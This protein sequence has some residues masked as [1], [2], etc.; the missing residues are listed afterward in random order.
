MIFRASKSSDG[1][2]PDK[3]MTATKP[4]NKVKDS[5]R[6]MEETFQPL[7]RHGIP[8]YLTRG[9]NKRDLDALYIVAYNLYAEQ[10][11]KQASQI[12]QT[13][14]FY[15]HFDKRGWLGNGACFQMLHRYEDAILCYSYVS[16][17]DAQ[18]PLPLFHAIECYIALKGYSEA[19]SALKILISLVDNKPQFAQLKNWAITMQEALQNR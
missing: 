12:F 18:D 9:L 6:K 11:Y 2:K 5:I 13:I 16:L 14:S 19:H 4:Q 15:N 8:L 10:K 17:I 7:L 3:T 1:L